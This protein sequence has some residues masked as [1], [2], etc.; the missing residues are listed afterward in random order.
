MDRGIS[1]TRDMGCIQ[2]EKCIER[3]TEC[4][5]QNAKRERQYKESKIN[6]EARDIDRS[7]G[8]KVKK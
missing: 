3:Q 4:I 8:G 1:R 5:N 2:H 6:S 7:M